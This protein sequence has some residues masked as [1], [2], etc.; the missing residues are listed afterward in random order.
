MSITILIIIVTVLVSYLAFSNPKTFEQLKHYPYQIQRDGS[1]YR[2]LTGG[3]L[4]GD[5][6]H[7][8]INMYVFYLFGSYVEQVYTA[9]FGTG[10]GRLLYFLLYFVSLIV[11]NFV[12][13][14]RH[15]QN[16]TFAS[17]GASGAVS[18]VVFS[19]IVFNPWSMLL[20][21]FIIPIPAIV[22]AVLYLF[23]SFYASR[24]GLQP[25]WDHEGHLYGSLAGLLFT[26]LLNFDFLTSFVQKLMHPSFNF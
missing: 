15:R 23:Y 9:E 7:L 22:F 5:W 11:A 20:L 2:I 24:R 26:L 12:T 13:F 17:V 25:Y 18:G 8:G 4:H 1:Y 16:P 6:M 19:F 10:K 3:L 14:L 21:F